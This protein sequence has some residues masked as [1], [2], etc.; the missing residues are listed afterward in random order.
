MFKKIFERFSHR[1]ESMASDSDHGV[2]ESTRMRL[3]LWCQEAFDRNWNDFRDDVRRLLEYRH[4][5]RLDKLRRE[6]IEGFLLRCS[7]PELFDFIE[8]IF[9]V[10]ALFHAT[11]GKQQMVD[12]LNELLRVNDL[13]YHVTDFV[14]EEV[15][16]EVEFLPGSTRTATGIEVVAL[17]KVV[18]RESE[19]VHAQAVAPAL[20]LLRR[21]VFKNANAEF[22]EALEDYRTG[23]FRDCLTKCCSSFESVL[24]IL[25]KKKGWPYDEKDT[26]SKLVKTV[27][28][29]TSLESFYE[30]TLVLVATLRN[31]LSKSHGAGAV[32]KTVPRHVAH[33]ALNLTASA[34]LLVAAEAGES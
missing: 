11:K 28:D 22:L 1:P 4:P 29:N 23:D 6:G 2:P 7:G 16:R 26:A 15:Q 13:P 9:Q 27:L 10:E 19:V 20:Q 31:K 3:V 32:T 17:P 8:D 18:M 14:E 25:C 34:I 24:K 21:P 33:F 12:E 5:E 30:A